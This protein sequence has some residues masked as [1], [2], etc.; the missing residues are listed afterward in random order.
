[1]IMI[2]WVMWVVVLRRHA[3]RM[4]REGHGDGATAVLVSGLPLKCSASGACLAGS[5]M[6]EQL[7]IGA[8]AK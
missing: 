5:R 7:L 8:W 1:M 4:G 6:S 2:M 3:A